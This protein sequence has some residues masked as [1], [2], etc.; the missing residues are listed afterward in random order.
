MSK[1][2]QKHGWVTV[3]LIGLGYFFERY[4]SPYKERRRE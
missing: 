3:F 1:W 4:P 2:I